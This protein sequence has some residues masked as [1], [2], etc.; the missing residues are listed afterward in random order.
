[1]QVALAC[2]ARERSRAPELCTPAY[3]AFGIGASRNA[4]IMESSQSAR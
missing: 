3:W 4:G 1:M 2:V